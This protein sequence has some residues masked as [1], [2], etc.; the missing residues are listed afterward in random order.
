MLAYS[1]GRGNDGIDLCLIEF[2]GVKPVNRVRRKYSGARAVAPFWSMGGALGCMIVGESGSKIVS[3]FAA[4]G[5][6]EILYESAT[7]HLPVAPAWSTTDKYI[8][9][10]QAG[11]AH[12]A[13]LALLDC[14]TREIVPLLTKA[15]P[16]AIVFGE[17]TLSIAGGEAALI[18]WPHVSHKR[19]EAERF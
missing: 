9:F 12:G 18:L 10:F 8:A 16:G 7:Q 14:D 15:V 13:P 5:D 11:S 17:E 2:Q 4:E 3:M 1:I 19:V 6:E